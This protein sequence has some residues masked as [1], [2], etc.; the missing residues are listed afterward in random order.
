[1]RRKSLGNLG[2]NLALKHLKNKGYRFIDRNFRSKFGE[3]DLIF[4]NKETLVFIEVK[5]RTSDSFGMP[6][7]SID[8]QKKR[9]LDDITSLYIAETGYMGEYRFDV[10][11]IKKSLKTAINHLKNVILD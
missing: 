4:Q 3:I 6:E 8:Q 2:E 1:M 5:T 7:E 11:I 10:I 9:K